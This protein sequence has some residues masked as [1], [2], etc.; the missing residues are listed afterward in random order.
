MGSDKEIFNGQ[1]ITAGAPN[2]LFCKISVRRSKYCLER[3][4]LL[5]TAKKF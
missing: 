2:V 3:L 5:R 1:E 4:L